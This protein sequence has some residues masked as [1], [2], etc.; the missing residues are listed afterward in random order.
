MTLVRL[1][2]LFFVVFSCNSASEKIIQ[3]VEPPWGYVFDDWQGSPI[4]VITYI[5]PN[6]TKNTPLL[7][8]VPGASRDA[9]R[10]HA[11]WLDLAKKNHFSVL[12]IGAK[13]SFFPDEYSYNAGGVITP[14]GE[15]VDE[16]KWLFT[17]IEP[18]FID[19]KKRYGFTTKK[20]Y[21]FGHSAGGGFVHRYL[22]FNPRA[23]IIKAVAANPA[24]VTLPDSD[25]RYPFGIKN[26]P[27]SDK[28]I[29]S[30]VN[31]DLAIILGE[32]DLG[33]RTKPLSNGPDARAQGPNCLARGKLLYNETKRKAEELK[34]NFMWELITVPGVGHDN[35][36]LAPFASIYLF[37][38]KEEK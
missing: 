9:Q 15:L 26:A 6:A 11:S 3:Q 1:L 38:D 21:L 29:K 10:F 12:T 18:L 33:P 19:F 5:P 37:G 7:I 30:W 13:K 20:F 27:I 23:P 2:P 16:S 25:I 17:V 24:F 22:L 14:S 8:V 4:D 31:M 32:D 34:A 35:Y 36:N 28:N